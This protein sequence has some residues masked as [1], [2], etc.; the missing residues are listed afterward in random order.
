MTNHNWR[1]FLILLFH[2]PTHHCCISRPGG[3]IK[4]SWDFF[5]IYSCSWPNVSKATKYIFR[6]LINPILM[7]IPIPHSFVPTYFNMYHRAW[8]LMPLRCAGCPLSVLWSLK[9]NKKGLGI[10]FEYIEYP[11]L[12]STNIALGIT[13]RQ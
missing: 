11:K 9:V 3:K 4:E 7:I 12:N 6:V 8:P 2:T 13:T 1:P 10:L 5:L